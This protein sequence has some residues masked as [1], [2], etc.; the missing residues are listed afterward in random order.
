MKTW[1]LD[2]QVKV[3][4]GGLVTGNDQNVVF[5]YLSSVFD[6]VTADEET[7]PTVTVIEPLEFAPVDLNNDWLLHHYLEKVARDNDVQLETDYHPAIADIPNKPWRNRVIARLHD[8]DEVIQSDE[9]LQQAQ[10]DL[11]AVESLQVQLR[12]QTQPSRFGA[13]FDQKRLKALEERANSLSKEIKRF[14]ALNAGTI[15]SQAIMRQPNH[16]KRMIELRIAAGLSLAKLAARSEINQETLEYHEVT[17]Y[18]FANPRDRSKIENIC[19][20]PPPR[21]DLLGDYTAV[22]DPSTSANTDSYQPMNVKSLSFAAMTRAA[23]Q[24]TLHSKIP[25]GNQISLGVSQ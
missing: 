13:D 2:R 3:R 1:T 23:Y 18:L 20:E 15:S 11:A 17:G 5:Q 19:L 22:Y 9:Q 8:L 24:Y 10:D 4:T 6:E 21:I 16:F 25:L 14:Q 12:Q 7:W